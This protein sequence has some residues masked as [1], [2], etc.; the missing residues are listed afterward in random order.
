MKKQL[1][2]FL[3]M[4]ALCSFAQNVKDSSFQVS[5]TVN[6]STHSITLNWIIQGAQ[7]CQIQRKTI[8]D[9]SWSTVLATVTTSSYTDTSAKVGV[10]YDYRLMKIIGNKIY[11]LGYVSSGINLPYVDFRYSILIVIDSATNADLSGAEKSQL[12]KDYIADGYLVAWAVVPSTAKPPVV[13]AKIKAW[14]DKYPAIN[15]HCLLLGKVP[16]PYSGLQVPSTFDTPPDAHTEHGGAWP[17]DSYYGDMDGDWT[18][19]G[20]VSAGVGRTEN[21]NYASDGKFDHHFLPSDMDIQIGRVDMSNLPSQPLSELQLIKQ[22]LRKLHQYKTGVAK[23]RDMAF[24]SDNFGFLGGEMPM[25]SGWNNA[26]AFVGAANIKTAGNYF[27]TCKTQSFIFSDVMGAGSYTNCS[28]VGSSSRYKDSILTVFNAQFGS[29]FGDWDNSDNFLRSCLASKGLTLTTCW[30][31]RPHWY[32]QHMP[33]GY[34]VGFSAILSQNNETGTGYLGYA[35][36]GYFDRRISMTLLGDPTLRI[37]YYDPP[38]QVTATNVNNNTDVKLD[39]QA[40]NESGILGYHVYR[41]KTAGNIYY[42]LTSQPITGLT[43]TDDDPYAGTNYYMVKPIKLE[44]SNTG[45]YYNM[46]LGGMDTAFSVNGT[47][48]GIA[49]IATA[50]ISV[51][52]NPASQQV[53]IAGEEMLSVEVMNING[54]MVYE[55]TNE[56]NEGRLTIATGNWAKGLYIVKVHTAKGVAFTKLVVQ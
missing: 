4:T 36:G 21:K 16:V 41:A 55:M 3:C 56:S 13:K 34:S 33:L 25:R 9:L 17:T 14:Y 52:P 39:W 31:A 12:E 23:A 10:A 48:T 8:N 51:Y 2:T 24:I 49:T 22:Y 28:G 43:F 30:A 35:G 32:F 26:S 29:Y 54:Q 46:G 27:D 53:N 42:R 15:R 50:E 20:E 1:L 38:K 40:S 19:F 7:K 5:A 18:D 37:R 44:V 47:N 6:A 45:S 11:Q